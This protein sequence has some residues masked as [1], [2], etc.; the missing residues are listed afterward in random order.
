MKFGSD[1]SEQADCE[2]G[3]KRAGP[4]VYPVQPKGPPAYTQPLH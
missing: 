3:S 4:M 1:K 2:G